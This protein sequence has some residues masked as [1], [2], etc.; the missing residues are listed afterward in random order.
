VKR[1]V[2]P[3]SLV[4]DISLSSASYWKVIVP[5]RAFVILEI[6]PVR[7]YSKRVVAPLGSVVVVI[8]CKKYPLNY[9]LVGAFL[10]FPL[11]CF[12]LCANFMPLSFFGFFVGIF[13]C[14]KV[15]I[16]T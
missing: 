16:F 10:L 15:G 5:P 2:S 1:V 14:Q 7:V 9:A 12:S 4:S 13:I 8:N 11:P 6:L 3:F